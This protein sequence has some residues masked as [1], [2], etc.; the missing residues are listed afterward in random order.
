MGTE[1]PAWV[2]LIPL[3]EL[4][5]D[6]QAIQLDAVSNMSLVPGQDRFVGDPLR[7]ALA[8]LAEESRR[9][10]VVEAGGSAVG[11]LT[12]QAGAAKLA[13]W[14][15]DQSAWLLRGFLIDRRHQGKGL[16]TLAAAAAVEAARKLTVR[17]QSGESGV[18]LSVNQE[19]PAGLSAYR[20]AGFVDSGPYPGGSAGP[21]RTMFRSFSATAPA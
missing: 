13:G 16:G 20:R 1:P 12:L 19:N 15:D 9:P 7:M 11:L 8:G 10:Y 18:V 17:H 21:Q 5:S 2:W 3:A 4:D 14:P 6:A